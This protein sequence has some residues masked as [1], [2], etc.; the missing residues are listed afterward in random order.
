[1]RISAVMSRRNPAW[2]LFWRLDHDSEKIWDNVFG[3]VNCKCGTCITYHI[4]DCTRNLGCNRCHRR[5]ET[6]DE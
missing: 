4:S 3:R 1:M 6:I 5:K 2:E